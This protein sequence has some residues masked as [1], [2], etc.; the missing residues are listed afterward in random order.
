MTG[1]LLDALR[2]I[3]IRRNGHNPRRRCPNGQR[4]LLRTNSE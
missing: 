2:D 1:A 4:L 3:S